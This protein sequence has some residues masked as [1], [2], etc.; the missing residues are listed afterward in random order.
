MYMEVRGRLAGAHA[1]LSL[2]RGPRD[3]TQ[4]FELGGKR[5]CPLSH[6]ASLRGCFGGSVQMRTVSELSDH[7]RMH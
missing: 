3:Q 7:H 2:L 1:P 4:V 6:P 5:L